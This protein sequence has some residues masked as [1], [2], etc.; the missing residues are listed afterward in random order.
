MKIFNPDRLNRIHRFI[1]VYI[2]LHGYSPSI[3]EIAADLGVSVSVV[4]YYLE[5]L[6]TIGMIDRDPKISRSIVLTDP[7]LW[8]GVTNV[9]KENLTG[10]KTN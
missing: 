7:S 10:Q 2:A 9:N 5:K 1:V 8:K 6:K 4:F 3:R